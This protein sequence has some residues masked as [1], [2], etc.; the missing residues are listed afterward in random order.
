M[1]WLV[2]QRLLGADSAFHGYIR[3]LPA[4]DDMRSHALYMDAAS[5]AS[6][7]TDVRNSCES[8][9]MRAGAAFDFVKN[10]AKESSAIKRLVRRR[11]Q[12]LD[13][14]LNL[15]AAA[16]LLSRAF[17]VKERMVLLP[18]I[19]LLNSQRT[20][21]TC[22]L[23]FDATGSPLVRATRHVR[24]GQEMFLNYGANKSDAE[25]KAFYGYSHEAAVPEGK[26]Q[27]SVPPGRDQNE[28]G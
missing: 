22:D 4:P 12:L 10:K 21:A 26:N 20:G 14:D 19:D 8:A 25:L 9:C 18:I 16:I 2:Q 24:H 17:K 5:M 23:F 28:A 13:R 3:T 6:L 1:L 27:P 7:P 15:W 11:P